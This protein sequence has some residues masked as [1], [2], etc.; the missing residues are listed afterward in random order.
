VRKGK[1]RGEEAVSDLPCFMYSDGGAWKD[2]PPLFPRP[3]IQ[4]NTV[5]ACRM[6]P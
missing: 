2:A 5:P 1:E 6:V 3:E 4:P